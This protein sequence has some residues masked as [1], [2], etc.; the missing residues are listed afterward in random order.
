MNIVLLG[1]PGAG[2]GTQAGR[3]RQILHVPHIASGDL[4]RS[5]R[6]GDSPAA[7]QAQEYMDRGEYV[8][9]Q[10]TI[11]VVL[12]RLTAPD[13]RAGF[14]LDGFPRTIPQASALD[15]ALAERGE[16]VDVALYITAP[17]EVLIGRVSGRLICPQCNTVYNAVTKP[18]RFDTR[19]DNDNHPLER[20]TD[21]EPHVVRR[22]LQAY[23]EQTL[24]L[25]EHYRRQG[26]LREVDGTLPVEEVNREVNEA[27]GLEVVS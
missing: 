11:E 23:L 25:I 26:I 17:E 19:C 9:D 8:P 22:R 7:R 13:A 21:E 1:P 20:R 4:F 24:P 18:P 3:L 14:I 16:R 27:V 12:D 2:K 6:R 10:L 5:L 15:H